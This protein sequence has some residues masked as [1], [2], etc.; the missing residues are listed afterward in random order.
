MWNKI[1]TISKTIL[2]VLFSSGCH[3]TSE[4][5]YLNYRNLYSESFEGC[6]SKNQG[7]GIAEF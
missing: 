4:T 6:K 1:I 2:C 3:N 5:G 7:I